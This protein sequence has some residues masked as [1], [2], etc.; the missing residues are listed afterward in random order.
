LFHHPDI[1]VTRESSCC[2]SSDTVEILTVKT[3]QSQENYVHLMLVYI[4]PEERL[5]TRLLLI[6]EYL[7]KINDNNVVIVGD[8]NPGIN[9]DQILLDFE[10]MHGVVQAVKGPTHIKGR[11]LDLVFT[12]DRNVS[13]NVAELIS[14]HRILKIRI[15]LKTKPPNKTYTRKVYRE[16][17]KFT[18][19][20]WEELNTAYNSVDW[21]N[22]LKGNDVDEMESIW[23]QVTLQ[24]ARD[25]MGVRRKY[26]KDHRTPLDADAKHAHKLVRQLHKM[27]KK[28]GAK[29]RESLLLKE[30]EAVKCFRKELHSSLS[31]NRKDSAIQAPERCS[32]RTRLVE[33]S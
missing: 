22:V 17:I 25:I 18:S 26:D 19:E 10:E 2:Y 24:K 28:A 27:A 31:A 20:K 14:D 11:T 23:R 30:K 8:F 7:Q 4:S 1:F 6:S 5:I 12:P 13:V 21:A 15:P 29:E 32:Q 16:V 9:D 3:M 33:A